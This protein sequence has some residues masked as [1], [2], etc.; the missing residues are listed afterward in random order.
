MGS[1]SPHWSCLAWR[2]CRS[3]RCADMSTTSV[4]RRPPHRSTE[5]SQAAV[6]AEPPAGRT[7]LAR[8]RRGAVVAPHY[9]ATA[10][11]LEILRA[12]GHAVD[13]GI[14]ANAVLGVVMPN[15]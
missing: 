1:W 9:L 14:A 10:A 4:V 15:A 2:S 7:V 13:A 6:S 11:G 5:S 3:S 8:G 12:G